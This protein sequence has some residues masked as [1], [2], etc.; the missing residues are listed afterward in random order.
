MSVAMQVGRMQ[1]AKLLPIVKLLLMENMQL[2]DAAGASAVSESA[3]QEGSPATP[4]KLSPTQQPSESSGAPFPAG[5][6]PA[7]LDDLLGLNVGFSEPGDEAP[8]RRSSSP[9]VSTPGDDPFA[10]LAEGR[11]A[12][13]YFP[14]SQGDPAASSGA[15]Q[16]TPHV[17][18]SNMSISSG[19]GA[20]GVCRPRPGSPSG[21]LSSTNAGSSE[22]FSIKPS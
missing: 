10:A 22:S 20:A 17:T 21:S 5:A 16:E 7:N 18:F 11:H 6:P 3:P 2:A 14:G 9:A 12:N 8:S 19:G 15:G 13:S 1:G 4:G